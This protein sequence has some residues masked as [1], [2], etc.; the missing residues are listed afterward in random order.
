[1]R[2]MQRECWTARLIYTT[3]VDENENRATGTS[4]SAAKITLYAMQLLRD[5]CVELANQ[6]PSQPPSS[7]GQHKATGYSLSSADKARAAAAQNFQ[8]DLMDYVLSK[9]L[10]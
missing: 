5:S 9:L 1:M 7:L 10:V 6:A 8:I 3:L 2:P 4:C